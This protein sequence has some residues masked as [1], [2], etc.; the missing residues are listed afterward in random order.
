MTFIMLWNTFNEN[1][2]VTELTEN[3]ETE[4]HFGNTRE[5]KKVTKIYRIYIMYVYTQMERNNFFF[6]FSERVLSKLFW[7]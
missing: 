2:M 5:E 7:G 6:N 1:I 4:F 3:W